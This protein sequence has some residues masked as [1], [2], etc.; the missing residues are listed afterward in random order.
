MS[1]W[2]TLRAI[3]VDRPRSVADLPLLVAAVAFAVVAGFLS[4]LPGGLGVRDARVDA[5][6][7]ARLRRSERPRRGRAHAARVASVGG[8][9]VWY[10]VYRRRR[11]VT[12]SSATA[13]SFSASEPRAVAST[14]R[15]ESPC[16]DM[17][18]VIIPVLDEAES[19]P[20]LVRELDRV[21]DAAR[22][23]AANRSSSTTARRTARGQ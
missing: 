17:L 6:T 15:S 10:P 1:L 16:N 7:G 18:S 22:L 23:R 2:A 9:R 13:S 12:Q 14:F 5:T 3:G 19:L 20:Q 4:M 21:A 8:C 11:R